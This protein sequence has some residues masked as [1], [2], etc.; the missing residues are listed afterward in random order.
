MG[1]SVISKGFQRAQWKEQ[2]WKWRV[3]RPVAT[4]G[5]KR[6]WALTFSQRV[7]LAVKDIDN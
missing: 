7:P 5:T 6:T 1:E 3:V 4:A 2:E